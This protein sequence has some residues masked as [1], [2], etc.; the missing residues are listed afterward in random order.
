VSSV[1]L[2]FRDLKAR[3]IAAN[4]TTLYRMMR[5]DGF[6]PAI[7]LSSQVRA[8]RETDIE[9]WIE[10]RPRVSPPLARRTG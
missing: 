9:E 8:W 3:G 7:M 6:P 10:S 2:R 4:W 5:E 1:L